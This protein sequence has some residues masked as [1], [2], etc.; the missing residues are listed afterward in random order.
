MKRGAKKQGRLKP[1]ETYKIT[2]WSTYNT[3]LKNRG[4]IT[5]WLNEEVKES[6]SYKGEQK[7]GGKVE[8]SD[9]SIEF[10][11]TM[12][13]LFK[14]GYRQTEG[15]VGDIMSLINIDL[16]VPC[17]SQIQRRSKRLEIDIRIRKGS[18]GPID[19]VIDSTGLKV[20]GEGEWKMRKHG[21]TKRRVWRKVHMG[22]DGLDLEILSVVVTGNEADDS[23]GGKMVMS[24][25][26][27]SKKSVAGDGAYDTNKFRGCLPLETEQLIPPK[28]GAVDS[29]G[30]NPKFAKRDEAVRRIEEVGR[31]GWKKETGY[32]I[33]S[34][35][36]VN[37]YRY[38]KIFGEGMI[39]RKRPFD[40]AE[41]RI[42]CKILNQFVEQGM[43]KS[44]KV[45]S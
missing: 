28:Q 13:H 26:K 17:Y 32:H 23:E 31:E 1:R 20:Y 7:P 38:K 34:K 16:S 3:S 2:N 4:R 18:K 41:V 15:F 24:Q 8:Y 29:K 21:K 43:P 44:Y 6:W 36:E 45:A 42:K 25:I 12:K 5:L 11:L 19:I 35:S 9:L 33:R 22:S 39:A 14:L 10:C 30:S 27:E 40:Q 37:M